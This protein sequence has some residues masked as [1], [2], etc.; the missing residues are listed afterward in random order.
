MY[1]PVLF[2][3]VTCL[4]E[5]SNHYNSHKNSLKEIHE[6]IN[7][8]QDFQHNNIVVSEIDSQ[9]AH[10]RD[11][12]LESEQI[13][14]QKRKKFIMVFEELSK[15]FEEIKNRC[16]TEVDEYLQILLQKH[17]AHYN[18]L[19]QK[20]EKYKQN[21]NYL[22]WKSVKKSSQS[23]VQNYFE[24]LIKQQ[25]NQHK[26][27][28]QEI[29]NYTTGFKRN[30]QDINNQNGDKIISILLD[31]IRQDF[32]EKLKQLKDMMIIPDE[33][34][35]NY[36]QQS[37]IKSEQNNNLLRSHLNLNSAKNNNS[38][39]GLLSKIQNPN[40]HNLQS[41]F[42]NNNEFFEDSAS[43]YNQKLTNHNLN[44]NN[45]AS[46]FFNATV[47][48]QDEN[49]GHNNNN[50]NFNFF[51]SKL[52]K[53]KDNFSEKNL[54]NTSHLNFFQSSSNTNVSNLH[55]F[56]QGKLNN[57]LQ[58]KNSKK[59]LLS[60][61]YLDSEIEEES[62][63]EE[64]NNNNYNNNNLN[65]KFNGTDNNINNNNY[66]NNNNLKES[67]KIYNQHV[68]NT[69]AKGIQGLQD[70]QQLQ[71]KPQNHEVFP[72]PQPKQIS[73]THTEG[74]DS[75]LLYNVIED[76]KIIA[77]GSFDCSIRIWN[78][79]K[80]SFDHIKTLKG[81]QYPVTCM[82][83]FERDETNYIASGD[84]GQDIMIWN[85]TLQQGEE[86]ITTLKGHAGGGITTLLYTNEYLVSS[87]KDLQLIVWDLQRLTPIQNI[88]LD[89]ISYCIE[90]CHNFLIVCTQDGFKIYNF[91]NDLENGTIYKL[92]SY[93]NKAHRPGIVK[94]CQIDSEEVDLATS[95]KDGLIKL[96][97]I[98]KGICVRQLKGHN[99][100]VYD[101]IYY[102]E[103]LF[104]SGRDCLKIWDLQEC[105]VEKKNNHQYS[106]DESLGQILVIPDYNC[107][108]SVGNGDNFIKIITF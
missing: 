14:Q 67:S 87:G 97:N 103:R 54:H 21:L 9:N 51:S 76:K 91:Q 62:D 100:C 108:L 61:N 34:Q 2:F 105:I 38:N 93:N 101:L 11:C 78:L 85:P 15:R 19:N 60:K 99:D 17:Q 4:L 79:E 41:N 107:V 73:Y 47:N 30:I 20:I 68:N 29:S 44:L 3:C 31:E 81:H 43:Q 59:N 7:S 84:M 10:L 64:I 63:Q 25:S 12:M 58:K 66:Y 89:C 106:R 71:Q 90:Q 53:E 49:I 45:I 22:S 6:F 95:G 26:E 46:N 35:I 56:Q 16:I 5:N 40:I 57:G 50:Q 80:N 39:F 96:W 27:F 33:E 69:V 36:F 28:F 42:M 77:T 32:R 75:L 88:K 94:I 24:T 104:S 8:A 52:H 55:Q 92:K 13:I 18:Y 102:N 72:L 65:T 1:R 83:K 74:I 37:R 98:A 23:E 86:L 48:N 82:R 70:L